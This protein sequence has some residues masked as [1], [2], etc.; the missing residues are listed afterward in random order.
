MRKKITTKAQ[1]SREHSKKRA[2]LR[3]GITLNREKYAQVIEQIRTGQYEG[4][5]KRSNNRW[6]YVLEV[7]GKD[8]LV[9]YDKK[10]HELITVL[11]KE[12]ELFSTV[13]E[14][15]LEVNNVN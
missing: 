3:Y 9:V 15:S 7:D 11:P 2:A 4:K 1:R 5:K 10:R 13:M 14:R 12:H 6:L 8:M